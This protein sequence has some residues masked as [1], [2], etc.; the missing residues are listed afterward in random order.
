MTGITNNIEVLPPSGMDDQIRRAAFQTIYGQSQL[1]MYALR[2]VPPIH[3]IV[4]NG[5]ITLE[6]AVGTEADKNVA[7]IQANSVPGSFAVTNNLRV[8]QPEEK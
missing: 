6:G 7:G 3:I 1:N 5:A 4:K 2:A 8:D